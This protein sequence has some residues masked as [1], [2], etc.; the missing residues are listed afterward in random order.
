MVSGKTKDYLFKPSD[1]AGD[2]AQFIF[3]N[4][5]EGKFIQGSSLG[6]T[7]SL[8]TK[9]NLTAATQN[10]LRNFVSKKRLHDLKDILNVTM[11]SQLLS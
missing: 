11:A 8:Q 4:W 9:K 6:K 7:Q 10:F 1:S 3:D 5:P 2:I